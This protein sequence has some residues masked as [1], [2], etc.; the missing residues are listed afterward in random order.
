MVGLR[1][2]IRHYDMTHYIDN[3]SY[4]QSGHGFMTRT[5]ISCASLKFSMKDWNGVCVIK[6]QDITTHYL[7]VTTE[8]TNSHKILSAKVATIVSIEHTK[9]I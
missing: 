9:F 8:S 3:P 5:N 7:P 1:P 4:L 6:G 2:N